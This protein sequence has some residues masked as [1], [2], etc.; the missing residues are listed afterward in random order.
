[1]ATN[2]ENPGTSVPGC[3][4]AAEDFGGSHDTS[5]RY[6][7][8]PDGTF[9]QP[10][11]HYSEPCLLEHGP[12]QCS[13]PECGRRNPQPLCGTGNFETYTHNKENVDCPDC[14]G[15]LKGGSR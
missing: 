10:A 1:M 14:L 9:G 8:N 15:I 13:D 7:G 6:G 2:L 5:C 12:G 4:C 11:V 3:T